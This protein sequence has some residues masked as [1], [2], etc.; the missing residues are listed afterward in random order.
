MAESTEVAL[1][2]FEKIEWERIVFSAIVIAAAVVLW[3]IIR[4][5]YKRWKKTKSDLFTGASGTAIRTVWDSP[6][7]R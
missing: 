5:V 4:T 7:C 3:L 1:R 2:W 6:G